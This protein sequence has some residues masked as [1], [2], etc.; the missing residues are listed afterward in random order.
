MNAI[1]S[2]LVVVL[3]GFGLGATV[4][5][6]APPILLQVDVSNP[7]AVTFTATSDFSYAVDSSFNLQE[8]IDLVSFFTAPLSGPGSTGT[9][10]GSLATPSYP[11]Y[12]YDYWSAD[13]RSGSFNQVD[14]NLYRA[15]E[16]LNNPQIFSTT[17]NAF[18][19]TSTINL[20]SQVAY[21]PSLLGTTGNI[22]PGWGSM[23]PYTVIGQWQV[24]AIPE[25][26]TLTLV[27]LGL[28][29]VASMSSR[30]RRKV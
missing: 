23:E 5:Q 28:L 17:A 6:A 9:I 11:A 27:G 13:D 15:T 20:S 4:T 18:T 19:G 1:F 30:F 16:G 2:R 24:V 22:V 12:P 8:G 25:P 3:L 10:S 29:G 21:L 7:A 26:T 14:L